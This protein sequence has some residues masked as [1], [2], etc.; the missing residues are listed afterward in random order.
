MILAIIL[1]L[2]I[3]I[4]KKNYSIVCDIAFNKIL[5]KNLNFFLNQYINILV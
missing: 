2:N 5:N 3:F 4:I 1:L